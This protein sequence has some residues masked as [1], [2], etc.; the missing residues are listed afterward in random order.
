MLCQNIIGCLNCCSEMPRS[1]TFPEIQYSWVVH[2]CPYKGLNAVKCNRLWD[3]DNPFILTNYI[4][5][6]IFNMFQGT[7]K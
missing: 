2:Q 6:I 1:V 5:A 7:A 4:Y 3:K